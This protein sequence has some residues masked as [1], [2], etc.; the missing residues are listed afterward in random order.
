MKC[1][2]MEADAKIVIADSL[3]GNAL[4]HAPTKTR[5]EN[6]LEEEFCDCFFQSLHANMM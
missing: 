5:D 2:R 3:Q 4:Q 1:P 6:A